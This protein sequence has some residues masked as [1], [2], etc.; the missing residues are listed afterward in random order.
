ML[1]AGWTRATIYIN[2]DWTTKLLADLYDIDV[3][4]VEKEQLIELVINWESSSTKLDKMILSDAGKEFDNTS[5]VGFGIDG[6][7]ETADKDFT[8]VR[9]TLEDNKFTSGLQK[10]MEQLAEKAGVLKAMLEKI[11]S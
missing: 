6:D 11:W 9:G 2:W 7:Q 8:A 3:R 5:K 4:T 1:E 10:E